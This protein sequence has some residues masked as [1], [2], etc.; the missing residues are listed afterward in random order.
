MCLSPPPQKTKK[1]DIT[2]H[3]AP[4]SICRLIKE[5]E[6]YLIINPKKMYKQ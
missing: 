4:V 1:C 5:M 3:Y 2:N 6:D